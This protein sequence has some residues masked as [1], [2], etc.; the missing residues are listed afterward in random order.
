M[1]KGRIGI[2]P[3][4]AIKLGAA[5]LV[6]PALVAGC[7]SASST[8][9][10]PPASYAAPPGESYVPDGPVP[11]SVVAKEAGRNVLVV[12]L[13]L[14]NELGVTGGTFTVR[15]DSLEEGFGVARE[16]GSIPHSEVTLPDPGGVAV[17]LD[18]TG[19]AQYGAA[20]QRSFGC[21]TEFY[22]SA[23][24]PEG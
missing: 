12:T 10:R 20:G 17:S 13:R 2:A 11:C 14:G 4:W 24:S 18:V 6:A 1:E 8:P 9:N 21:A 15:E 3:H 16:D 22:P 5:A 23:S 19:W 7:T